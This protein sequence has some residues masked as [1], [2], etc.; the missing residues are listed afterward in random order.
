M[1]LRTKPG[2]SHANFFLSVY[3]F[4]M[5]SQRTMP[6]PG[7]KP[8]V[9]QL[10]PD[11][12]PSTPPQ[13]PLSSTT[14]A[15]RP[16]AQH[17]PPQ[18]PPKHDTQITPQPHPSRP[19]PEYVPAPGKNKTTRK[20]DKVRIHRNTPTETTEADG[21]TILLHHFAYA[22]ARL[23]TTPAGQPHPGNSTPFQPVP[24]GFKQINPFNN[25][26]TT[27]FPTPSVNP[28]SPFPSPFDSPR[29]PFTS[30]RS[31]LDN[32]YFPTSPLIKP[33]SPSPFATQASPFAASPPT[34]PFAASKTLQRATNTKSK[35]QLPT[36]LRQTTKPRRIR[37]PLGQ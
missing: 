10:P 3:F 4:S 5:S 1:Y 32:P 17:Q 6:E 22:P 28:R 14:E 27:L 21:G 2:I 11:G 13:K 25:L 36:H 30:P 35:I 16:Q 12:S 31:T 26:H 23:E 24:M 37:T 20:N 18:H 33:S 15:P 19:P 7:S 29:S 9:D 8:Q 34:N